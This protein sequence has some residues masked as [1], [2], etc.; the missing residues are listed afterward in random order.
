ML[1]GRFLFKIPVLAIAGA[2]AAKKAIPA[3]AGTLATHSP[4]FVI[5]LISVVL[6]VGALSFIP[7]LSLGPIV[8][9]LQIFH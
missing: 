9:H 6:I 7:A 4:L 1:C 8:E 5:L 2:L 3:S